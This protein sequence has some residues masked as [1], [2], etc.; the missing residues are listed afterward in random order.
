[1]DSVSHMSSQQHVVDARFG[2]RVGYILTDWLEEM[3]YFG[4]ESGTSRSHR[5]CGL[6]L[7]LYPSILS[8]TAV[9]EL[10]GFRTDL[11]CYEYPRPWWIA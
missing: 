2:V 6:A 5:I 7:I 11:Y 4:C 10:S 9:Q 1:M 8:I 3:G